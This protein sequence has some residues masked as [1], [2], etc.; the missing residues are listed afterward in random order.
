MD[1]STIKTVSALLRAMSS[2]GSNDYG[3]LNHVPASSGLPNATDTDDESDTMPIW[4][5]I[6][7]FVL[8]VVSIAAAKAVTRVG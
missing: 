3:G 5:A 2:L 1:E 8:L 6:M 7:P 4:C